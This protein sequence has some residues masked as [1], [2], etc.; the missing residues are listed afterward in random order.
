MLLATKLFKADGKFFLSLMIL[1]FANENLD[2]YSTRHNE[3]VKFYLY[4]EISPPLGSFSRY[5]GVLG[6]NHSHLYAYL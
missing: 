3:I 6:S 1:Q 5:N 2:L 4:I